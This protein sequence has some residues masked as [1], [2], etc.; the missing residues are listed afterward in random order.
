DEVRARRNRFLI[1]DSV[2]RSLTYRI[3]GEGLLRQPAQ[4][5]VRTTVIWKESRSNV[6]VEIADNGVSAFTEMR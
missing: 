3:A 4:Q 1:P 2:R 6:R 5:T